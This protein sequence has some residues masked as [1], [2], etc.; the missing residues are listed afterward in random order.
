MSTIQN[1][2]TYEEWLQKSGQEFDRRIAITEQTLQEAVALAKQNQKDIGAL[3]SSMGLVIEYMVGGGIVG[4]FQDLGIDISSLSRDKTFG[5]R[6]TE[7]SGQIDVFLENG[8]LVILVE[9]KTKLTDDAVREHLERLEKY[10]LYGN[11]KRRIQGAIAGAVAP[12]NVIRFAQRQGL[13]VIIQSDDTFDLV[14]PPEGFK[15]K[16]W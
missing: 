7:E 12:D 15:A 3:T 11:E 2:L 8:D 16:E 4:Q 1:T 9:V 10:R 6:G 14:T 5:K 13:Y